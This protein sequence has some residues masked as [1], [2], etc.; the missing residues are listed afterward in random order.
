MATKTRQEA[1]T[2]TLENIKTQNSAEIDTIDNQIQSAITAG[3]FRVFVEY[4]PTQ[5]TQLYFR[6]GFGYTIKEH[7]ETKP[8][9]DREK[10]VTVQGVEISW[11]LQPVLQRVKLDLP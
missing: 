2:E 10:P 6:D 4:V 1:I 8:V 9:E 11:N 7:T 3:E 5:E